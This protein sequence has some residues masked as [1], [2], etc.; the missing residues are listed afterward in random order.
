MIFT[1]NDFYNKGDNFCPAATIANSLGVDDD[2]QNI[3]LG[4]DQIC[5]TLMFLKDFFK[6]V[7][8]EDTKS[9]KNYQACKAASAFLTS[10]IFFNPRYIPFSE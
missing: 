8:F 3:G 2:R 10:V 4:L 7:N 5:L 1:M 9:Q 6:K